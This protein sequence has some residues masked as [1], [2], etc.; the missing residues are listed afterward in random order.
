MLSESAW[1]AT[2]GAFFGRMID[3]VQVKG[4]TRP[5]AIYQPI[6][7]AGEESAEQARLCMLY[8]EAWQHYRNQRWTEAAELLTNEEV[9]LDDPPSKTLLDRVRHFTE[10][11]GAS[12]GPDWDGVWRYTTK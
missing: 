8:E 6:C 4:K 9:L 5:V 12:P 1:A 7:N 2:N 10:D 3:L 11:S